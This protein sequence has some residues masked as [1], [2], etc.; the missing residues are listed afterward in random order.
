M[1]SW[2]YHVVLLQC[3]KRLRTSLDEQTVHLN[4]SVRVLQRT[5]TW[6]CKEL[7]P[8]IVGPGTSAGWI[9]AS[10]TPGELTSRTSLGPKAWGPGTQWRTTCLRASRPETQ[11]EPML[12][13]SPKGRKNTHVPVRRPPG[14]NNSLTQQRVRPSASGGQ[15]ASLRPPFKCSSRP[16]TAS[17]T[18][19][20][21]QVT[22]RQGSQKRLL[23]WIALR[24][25][26]HRDGQVHRLQLPNFHRSYS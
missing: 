11:E 23:H 26:S 7:P 18:H 24:A 13:L 8:T 22:N 21:C 1:T 10:W 5:W 12:R 2:F 20:A 17:Q 3:G 14:R 15:T 16:T 9:P 4:A 19:P 6:T 25:G